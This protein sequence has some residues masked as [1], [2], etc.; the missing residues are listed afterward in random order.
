M[1]LLKV[2]GVLVRGG[3]LVARGP[4]AFLISTTVSWCYWRTEATTL[5]FSPRWRYRVSRAAPPVPVCRGAVRRDFT[6][7]H[8][9]YAL[10][11]P[12]VSITANLGLT[13]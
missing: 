13:R 10:R 9:P 11:Q 4:S 7:T 2:S 8:R 5:Q 12:T 1:E 6:H 3:E